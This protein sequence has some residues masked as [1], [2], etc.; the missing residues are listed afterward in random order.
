MYSSGSSGSPPVIAWARLQGIFDIG[1]GVDF[2]LQI[3][4]LALRFL[5]LLRELVIL[6]VGFGPFLILRGQHLRQR[7]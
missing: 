6:H 4:V 2:F 7:T 5:E 1:D 3:F